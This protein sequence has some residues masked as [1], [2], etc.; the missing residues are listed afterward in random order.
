MHA[1][2][3]SARPVA[4]ALRKCLCAQVKSA[5]VLKKKVQACSKHSSFSQSVSMRDYIIYIT[6]SMISVLE[7]N[8]DGFSKLIMTKVTRQQRR[9][10]R[11]Q[12]RECSEYL[13][14][15]IRIICFPD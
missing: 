2:S 10:S 14:F 12:T 8:F 1:Q 13:N 3:E 15:S 11:I 5:G 6:I 4:K 7:L 9:P